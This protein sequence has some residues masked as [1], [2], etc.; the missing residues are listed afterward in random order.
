MPCDV[1]E[2]THSMSLLYSAL[3]APPKWSSWVG[4]KHADNA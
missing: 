1:I 4:S 2:M 3:S